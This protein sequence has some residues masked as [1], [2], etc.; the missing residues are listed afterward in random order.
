MLYN[1]AFQHW[2]AYVFTPVFPLLND[3]LLFLAASLYRLQNNRNRDEK[4]P[5]F[6]ERSD[7]S[8]C[9]KNPFKPFATEQTDVSQRCNG[10]TFHPVPLFHH[11][12]TP[13]PLYTPHLQTPT[14]F[15]NFFS[16]FFSQKIF[17]PIKRNIHH[18]TKFFWEYN[19][20]NNKLF[21]LYT[22]S[23]KRNIQPIL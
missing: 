7:P 15:R 21:I 17:H 3:A 18:Q 1:I 4:E 20:P 22:F 19:K 14:L 5:L 10:W 8:Y 9:W 12:E 2:K 13:V 11:P 23:K 6:R 16:K